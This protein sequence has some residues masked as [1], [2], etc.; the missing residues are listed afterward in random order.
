MNESSSCLYVLYLVTPS[1][2]L[3]TLVV[4]MIYIY[5]NS[6]MTDSCYKPDKKGKLCFH[7]E[8]DSAGNYVIAVRSQ[9]KDGSSNII[10]NIIYLE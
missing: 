4:L 7:S 10:E 1:M 5:D 6:I 8:K 3:S 2:Y 9:T